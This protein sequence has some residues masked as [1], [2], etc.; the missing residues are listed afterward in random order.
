MDD[1]DPPHWLSHNSISC[2]DHPN[3]EHGHQRN[4]DN[5]YYRRSGWRHQKR[6]CQHHTDILNFSRNIVTISAPMAHFEV[7]LPA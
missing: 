3:G 1:I 7:I 2:L 4:V 6:S 5:V